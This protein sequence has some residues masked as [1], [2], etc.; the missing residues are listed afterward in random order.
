MD[1]R[2]IILA[3]SLWIAAIIVVSGRLIVPVAPAMAAAP[4]VDA[5]AV[6]DAGIA[7][8]SAEDLEHKVEDLEAKIQKVRGP[9][10]HDLMLAAAIAAGLSLLI[11][12]TKNPIIDKVFHPKWIPI[13]TGVLGVGVAVLMK[14]STS[15]SWVTAIV[16][17]GGAPGHENERGKVRR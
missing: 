13:A 2:Q 17:A 6:A 10:E 8:G 1:R 7:P 9:D 3:L 5:G 15:A 12:I 14:Y 11:A 4:V 16:V